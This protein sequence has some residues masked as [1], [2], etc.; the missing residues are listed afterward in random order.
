MTT[1]SHLK[2]IKY[3]III[4]NHKNKQHHGEINMETNRIRKTVA[5]LLVVMFLVTV[6]AGTVSAQ[7]RCKTSI[8]GNPTH[9]EA[10]LTVHFK[11][12]SSSDKKII[13]WD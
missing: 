10:P 8:E 5:S 3:L 6:T 7:C 13:S 11:D 1:V 4:I 12:K 2:I 9:G